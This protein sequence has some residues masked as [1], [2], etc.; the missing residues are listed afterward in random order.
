[1]GRRAPR[2]G[3]TVVGWHCCHPW[4]RADPERR[5]RPGTPPHRPFRGHRP[6][7]LDHGATP[8]SGE[9]RQE[10]PPEMQKGFL[11]PAG[12]LALL[13]LPPESAHHPPACSCSSSPQQRPPSSVTLTMDCPQAWGSRSARGWYRGPGL[14]WSLTTLSSTTHDARPCDPPHQSVGPDFLLSSRVPTGRAR[15]AGLPPSLRLCHSC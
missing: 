14:R 7:S 2:G 5:A 13:R 15:G 11:F 12:G 10:E 6:G 4:L 1:M 9:S 3:P 8:C